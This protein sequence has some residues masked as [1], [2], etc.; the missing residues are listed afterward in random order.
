[1]EL[2]EIATK[3]G[4]GS[5]IRK[6]LSIRGVC[7][8]G[9]LAMIAADEQSF[10]TVF[11][12]PLMAG[13]T[14]G[15]ESIKIAEAD[16]PIATAVLLYMR[17]LAIKDQ[18]ST[19]GASAPTGPTTA[20]DKVPQAL[21]P[22]VW[23]AQLKKYE[24]VT[25]NGRNRRFPQQMDRSCQS[26][27][28]TPPVLSK[29]K[30]K[31]D[32]VI[33]VDRDRL[34][35]EE[36]DDSWEPRSMVAV[37]DALN[38][39]SKTFAEGLQ[40]VKDDINLYQEHMA[41]AKPTGDRATSVSEAPRLGIR[42]PGKEAVREVPY[43]SGRTFTAASG[44]TMLRPT[45][46][47]KGGMAHRRSKDKV[48]WASGSPDVGHS[49]VQHPG[50]RSLGQQ[51]QRWDVSLP[52]LRQRL[53]KLLDQ[54]LDILRK[55]IHL[56]F[57]SGMGSASLALQ[58]LGKPI[59]C[60]F[61]WEI[62]EAAMR[63]AKRATRKL[64]VSQRGDF[65]TGRAGHAAA[66]IRA[67][68][69]VEHDLL[70]VTAGAPCP[71][72]SKLSSSAAGREGASGDLF[73]HFTKFLAKLLAHFPGRKACLLAENVVMKNLGDVQFFS[74]ALHA[75]PV[76][77]DARSSAPLRWAQLPNKLAQ[78][79]LQVTPDRIDDMQPDGQAPSVTLGNSWHVDVAK[80]MLDFALRYGV[81]TLPGPFGHSSTSADGVRDLR[82]AQ[83]AAAAA[84]LPMSRAAEM[85]EHVHMVP[86]SSMWEHWEASFSAVHPSLLPTLLDPSLEITVQRLVSLGP[87]RV[88]QIR[89]QVIA[90]IQE[91]RDAMCDATRTWHDSL[92][93]HIKRAYTL[94][95]GYIVQ[96]P[97]FIALLR[98]AGYPDCAALQEALTSASRLQV[99]CHAAQ[100]GVPDWTTGIHASPIS[101]EAF[102]TLNHDYI[103]RKLKNGR[104]DPEWQTMLSEIIAEV[105]IGRM[106]GPFEAPSNWPKAC[107]P[108]HSHSGLQSC[109]PLPYHD[110]RV[111]GAFSVTQVGSD[112]AKKVRRCE[113]FRR[114]FHN[115]TIGAG[116]IPAHDTI[117]TYVGV[118]Q[119]LARA[120]FDT[121][122]WCQ[123]LWA[124]YRQFPVARPSDSFTLLAT[125]S[126]P[127]L[128]AHA[129]LP[130]GAASSLC[131][132]NRFVDALGFLARTLL[133]LL[134][135]H[136]VDDIG[137][138]DTAEGAVP[139]FSAFAELC[140]IF[141]MR[142][143][144][145]K[146][147]PPDVKHK[148]LGVILEILPH[149]IRLAPSP[150]RLEKVI[151]TIQQ[152]LDT[153][154]L[155]PEAAR[156]MTCRTSP[157]HTGPADPQ[158]SIETVLLCF[159]SRKALIYAL[160]ILAQIVAAI[161]CHE[162]LCCPY[163]VGFC[164][165]SAGHGW[166]ELHS[167]L[168][169]LWHI[170]LR[171]ATDFD[172]AVDKAAAALLGLHW[173]FV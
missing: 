40:V 160:E 152:A 141:G 36:Q 137:G 55:L 113:D 125:P 104:V 57:F 107:V 32:L 14:S 98:G 6:Y 170:L 153:D 41:P 25:I 71:D 173:H 19:A 163:W 159:S 112:G 81:I 10:R 118:L 155:E 46:K 121:R 106:T 171:V 70:L 86:V 48:T 97:L 129:V 144:P 39:S 99:S 29:R 108:V 169:D 18:A 100:A 65:E 91:L 21:P 31:S 12:A 133:I 102:A 37:C 50:R 156:I 149:G 60:T 158:G 53:S 43:Q 116:D 150:D 22:G 140:E 114:S 123:D 131:C 115:A 168:H 105:Q 64:V 89:S 75:E 51:R 77:A 61:Q 127:T 58:R 135:I 143:K 109:M 9:T 161:S 110:I 5:E 101:M 33:D 27:A 72:F 172:F 28:L 134:I 42:I 162:I 157:Q 93:P 54:D 79:H 26:G 120:G 3:A 139:G 49:D 15:P 69:G 124:A 82:S 11:V 78:L 136:Y 47:V 94:P 167:D 130:C 92:A 23:A 67:V 17:Q 24:D 126:G 147:Q 80:H 45:P 34:V 145:S 146:A 138:P 154:M 38:G 117:H 44:K 16:K 111:A 148:L 66:A 165:N 56:D 68:R 83:K 151:G 73:V 142:L 96:I 76:V 7:S 95:D 122:V 1:M 87:E 74:R 84:P 62:D 4:A 103:V 128:W 30:Q 35:T 8:A 20:D 2:D 90:D 119:G 164:D 63:I 88:N 52:F 132:F 166:A 59:R 85:S 13:F